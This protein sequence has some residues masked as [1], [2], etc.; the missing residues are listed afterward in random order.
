MNAGMSVDEFLQ[1]LARARLDPSTLNDVQVGA[2]ESDLAAW[3]HAQAGLRLPDELLGLYRRANGIAF[4]VCDGIPQGYIRLL[5][6]RELHPVREAPWGDDQVP[7]D[8]LV[9]SDHLDGSSFA[10]LELRSGR[11]LHVDPCGIDDKSVFGDDVATFLDA[12]WEHWVEGLRDRESIKEPAVLALISALAE[13]LPAEG[14]RVIDRWPGDTESAGVCRT[15]A[16]ETCV[17]FSTRKQAPGTYRIEFERAGSSEP[18]L[19]RDGV[20][21]SEA[22]ELL[23]RQLR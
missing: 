10:V 17:V 1:R 3:N 23:H 7:E 5:P 12:I 15:T 20:T 8:W 18:A 16:L 9:L 6:L 22:V 4:G 19:I 14:W 2:S 13:V 11:Y 21:M